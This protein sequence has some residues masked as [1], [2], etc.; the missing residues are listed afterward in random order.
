MLSIKLYKIKE[1]YKNRTWEM[2]KVTGMNKDLFNVPDNE[3]KLNY[4]LP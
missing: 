3:N 2:G 1:N 4:Y